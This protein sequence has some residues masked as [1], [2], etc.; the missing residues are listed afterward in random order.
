MAHA[1]T[2]ETKAPTSQR[3]MTHA[4]ALALAVMVGLNDANRA[5]GLSRT[6]GYTLARQGEYPIRVLRLGNQ[7]RVARSDL[8]RFLGIDEPTTDPVGSAAA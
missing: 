4:E 8:L 1:G 6:I 2:R 7:Y 3:G 5:L